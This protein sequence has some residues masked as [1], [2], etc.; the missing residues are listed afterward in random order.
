MLLN[1]CDVVELD[2]V[3]G[4]IEVIVAVEV[5]VL[6]VFDDVVL[7]VVLVVHPTP[8]DSQQKSFFICDQP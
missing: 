1:V 2:V 4:V 7:V 8:T 3:V 6:D 5:D